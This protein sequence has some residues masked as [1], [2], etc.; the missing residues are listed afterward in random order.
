M[1]SLLS[2]EG[3]EK[4]RDIC[5]GIFSGSWR[6]A[7]FVGIERTEVFLENFIFNIFQ[8][9]SEGEE[10]CKDICQILVIRML[11]NKQLNNAGFMCHPQ[12][13]SAL[14]CWVQAWCKKTLLIFWMKYKVREMSRKFQVIFFPIFNRIKGNFRVLLIGVVINDY[15]MICL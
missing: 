3:K 13:S 8:C 7:H 12:G 5:Q 4:C 14:Q 1:F 15:L 10:K 9:I 2:A 11:L 6:W